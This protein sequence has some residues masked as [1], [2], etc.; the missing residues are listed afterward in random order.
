LKALSSLAKSDIPLLM[1]GMSHL[2][3]PL[4][5]TNKVKTISHQA[6]DLVKVK[7]K[8]APTLSLYIDGSLSNNDKRKDEEWKAAINSPLKRKKQVTIKVSL[9]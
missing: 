1:S 5:L 3:A 4:V 2:S 7:A 8:L 9:L 6:L